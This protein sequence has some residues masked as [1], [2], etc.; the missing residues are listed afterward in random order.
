[1]ISKGQQ[2][3]VRLYPKITNNRKVAA[4]PLHVKWAYFITNAEKVKGYMS[5]GSKFTF[6]INLSFK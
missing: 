6:T 3:Q 1:M 5:I 4:L 2:T